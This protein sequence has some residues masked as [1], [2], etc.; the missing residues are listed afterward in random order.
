MPNALRAIVPMKPIPLCKSR[1][2]SVLDQESR[3]ALSLEMLQHVLRALGQVITPIDTLVVGGDQW[4]KHIAFQESA[5]W[6]RDPGGNLNQAISYGV[7][8][9]FQDGAAAV[10]VL[11]GDLALLTS[12]EIDDMILLCDGLKNAVIAPASADGGTNAILAAKGN[13]MSPSYGPNSFNRH[14]ELAKAMGTPVKISRSPGLAFDLDTP[15]DFAWYQTNC[16]SINNAL[17]LW[18]GRLC[19]TQPETL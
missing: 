3:A 14:M 2:A 16:H 10:L 13:M 11:P 6:L 8:R 17:N 19:S 15:S 7:N 1:L 18:K 12:T 4:V 5:G 9:A